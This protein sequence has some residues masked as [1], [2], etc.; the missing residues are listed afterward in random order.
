MNFIRSLISV[1]LIALLFVSI[2]GWFWAGDQ[3]SA[4]MVGS[5]V[6]LTLCGVS[7]LGCLWLLWS[8]KSGVGSPDQLNRADLA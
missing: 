5:R 8:A 1:F 3:P 6:V 2:A 7:S 4:K